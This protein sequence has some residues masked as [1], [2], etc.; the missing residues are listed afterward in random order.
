MEYQSVKGNTVAAKQFRF[1]E[2]KCNFKCVQNFPPEKREE[3]YKYFY[4]LKEWELQT[5]YIQSKIKVSDVKRKRTDKD[6]SRRNFSHHYFFTDSQGIDRE[7]CKNVFKQCHTLRISDQ[8]IAHSLSKTFPA[9]L[10]GKHEPHNKT[11]TSTIEHIRD[12]IKKFPAYQS[13]YSRKKNPHRL[14]LSPSLNLKIMYRLYLQSCNEQSPVIK[15]SSL[16]IFREVFNNDFNYHFHTPQKDTCKRCNIF[17][18]KF[19]YASTEEEKL[20]YQQIL[21]DHHILAEKARETM[22]SDVEASKQPDSDTYVI[23]FDLM[24]TLPTPDL[25]VGVCYYKRQMWT[26]LL[27]IHNLMTHEVFTYLWH[28]A[29]ASRGPQEVASCL[30]HFFKNHATD[31]PNVIMYSDQCGGQ[32]KNFK[33]VIMMNYVANNDN[34]KI[35]KIDHK[36]MVS[37]HSYLACDQDFGLI[38]KEKRYHKNIYVPADWSKV[39]KAA[40]K[41]KPFVVHEITSDNFLSCEVLE[42]R[43]TNRKKTEK[44]EKVRWRDIVHIQLNKG[45]DLSMFYKYSYD[46]NVN[47]NEVSLKKRRASDTVSAQLPILYKNGR[48]IDAKKL[49]D[50]S[51][52]MHFIPPVAQ[53]FYKQLHPAENIDEILYTS[54]SDDED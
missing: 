12:F 53:E 38:E 33:M 37:G 27:G 23:C 8:R 43:V 3:I 34:L 48:K 46:K 44:G 28:E 49:K 45:D 31:R 51:E 6:I 19:D 2:C 54:S 17:K 36:F 16:Y 1:F 39:A 41:K 29:Q 13:H 21:N 22:K 11:R 30:I 14:Y 35:N 15:P 32:N 52:L 25:D 40:C 42:K 7:V 20:N 26:Y 9:D 24:K 10:R 50:I 18:N 5:M 47:F 4:G